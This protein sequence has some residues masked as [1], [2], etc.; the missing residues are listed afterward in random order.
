MNA[1]LSSQGNPP[2]PAE[3]RLE[4]ER[5]AEFVDALELLYII[6]NISGRNK[7]TEKWPDAAFYIFGGELI[8]FD[9]DGAPDRE[10]RAALEV[11]AEERRAE[12]LELAATIQAKSV[13]KG[14]LQVDYVQWL[15][16]RLG[17]PLSLLLYGRWLVDRFLPPPPEEQP[18]AEVDAR[19]RAAARP[20]AKSAS[21]DAMEHVR[22]I[23]MEA[24]PPRAPREEKENLIVETEGVRPIDVAPQK[25]ES[26]APVINAPRRSGLRIM[27][28]SDAGPAKD[29]GSKD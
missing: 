6:N 7:F 2:P 1:P 8:G 28:I 14:V 19:S 21:R 22:P 5:Y 12:L 16:Q 20:A 15:T 18:R 24:E 17:R 9:R 3:N 27:G 25:K 4:S 29:D 13:E 23:S 11:E 10:R 26:I